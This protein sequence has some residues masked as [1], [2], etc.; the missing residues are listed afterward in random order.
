[1]KCYKKFKGLVGSTQNIHPYHLYSSSTDKAYIL[2]DY[3][4]KQSSLDDTHASLPTDIHIP[5][6]ILDLI[7]VTSYVLNLFLHSG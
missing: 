1:M 4:T 2:N 7:T 6:Y 3:F 5:D